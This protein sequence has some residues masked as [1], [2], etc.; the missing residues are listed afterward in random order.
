MTSKW[1]TLL[2]G[3]ALFFSVTTSC[4]GKKKAEKEENEDKVEA[5]E[6]DSKKESVKNPEDYETDAVINDPYE[7]LCTRKISFSDIEG[8]DKAEL[9]VMRNYIFARHGYRFQR[10]DLFVFFSRFDWY[11]G[12]TSDMEEVMNELS[13]IERYNV[14]YIKKYE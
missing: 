10:N 2:T 1:F 8:E 12:R 9:E 13:E 6:K 3:A 4:D 5:T 7:Y 11:Y 14:E